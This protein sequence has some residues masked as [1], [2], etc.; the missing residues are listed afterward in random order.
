MASILPTTCSDLER[1]LESLGERYAFD[2]P[3]KILWNPDKCPENLLIYLAWA[4][5]VDNWDDNWSIDKKR[6][7]VKNSLDVHRLKGTSTSL[8]NV[9]ESLGYGLGIEYWHQNSEIEKGKFKVNVRA[10]NVEINEN[11][12]AEITK[13]INNNKR[14]TLH[15]DSFNVSTLTTADLRCFSY[16]KIGER[17]K[18][19]VRTQKPSKTTA[20]LFVGAAVVVRERIKILVR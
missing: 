2:T 14:G 3:I 4:L 16:A 18:I 11:T 17:V 8:A 19:Y 9:A 15:L 5:S 1:K 7:I 13:V 10:S 20:N 6:R 12:Y